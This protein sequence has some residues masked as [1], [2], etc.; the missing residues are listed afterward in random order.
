MESTRS[1]R[2]SEKIFRRE[3]TSPCTTIRRELVKEAIASVRDAIFIGIVLSSIVLIV[4]LR[5][6]GSSLVAG[7]VIPVTIAMTFVVLKLLGQ[8][9]NLM[10][11]GG[12]A[13]AVGLVI[14]DAIVVVENIVLH[15]DAGQGRMQAVQSALSELKVPLVGSTLTPVVIFLPLILITGVTGT[16]FRALA[17]TMSIRLDHF[18]GTGIDLDPDSESIF[19]SAQG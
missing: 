18:V 7:L 13:A 9:F 1:W 12:L 8:T 6:W 3:L 10:T 5:D 2:K 16:F 17:I 19:C 14:D 15:R 11:L 4:F